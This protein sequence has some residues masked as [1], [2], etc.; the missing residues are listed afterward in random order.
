MTTDLPRLLTPDAL[1]AVA[2]EAAD[3]RVFRVEVLR[4][5]RTILEFEWYVWA[6][7]DPV[8]GVGIDPLARIPDDRDA[9]L[10]IRLKYL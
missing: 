6:L 10:A 5:L 1:H 2:V 8:T 3:S 4:R 7:T 9:A